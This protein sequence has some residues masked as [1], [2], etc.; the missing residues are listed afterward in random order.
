LPDLAIAAEGETAAWPTY[1]R[2]RPEFAPDLAGSD[3]VCYARGLDVR[4]GRD[5]VVLVDRVAPYFRRTD[6]RFSSHAQTPPVAKESSFAAVIAGSGWVYFADPV[7]REYRKSGNLA[8]RDLWRLAM[9]RLAGDAWIGGGL[10]TTVLC[11]PRRKGNDLRLTLLH[12]V[13][14]RKAL[15]IDIIEER[16]SFAGLRLNLPAAAK[17]VKVFGTGE[18]LARHP[19]GGFALPAASGRLL[20]EIPGFFG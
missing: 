5:S 13:P 11:V 6:T 20:L 12:Y 15:E 3:R 19:D 4:G 8:A 7:F 17:T 18:S 2:A 9:R 10:P 1:W 14:V 16:M